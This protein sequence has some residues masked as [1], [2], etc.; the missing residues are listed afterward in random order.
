MSARSG[1]SF[2]PVLLCAV[3]AFGEN[4][5]AEPA[6]VG[7]AFRYSLAATDGQAAAGPSPYPYLNG[8]SP[9]GPTVANSPDPLVGY[10][11]AR[12]SAADG[13]Q[14]YHLRPVAVRTSSPASFEGLESLTTPA[15]NVLVKGTGSILFD[16]GVESAAWLEFDSADLSGSVTMSISEYNEPAIVNE[17]AQ[18]P[19][20]TKAPARHENVYR[21]ELNRELY[22]GV[23]FGWIHVNSFEK[24]W[25]ITG[26]RLVCQIKPTNYTGAFGCSDP[27]LERIWYTG[28]YGV[29]LNL[30]K[31]Y[32]GAILMERSDR[33]SWTGDAHTSQGVALVAFSNY[34]FVRHNIDRTAKDTN[35]IESYSLYWILSLLDYYGYTGDGKALEGYLPVVEAKLKRGAEVYARPVRLGFFGHDDRIGATFEYPDCVENQNA[36]RMLFLRTCREVSRAAGVAGRKELEAKY[37]AWADDRIAE[38]RK[39]AEWYA[40]YGI[41]ACAEAVNAGFTTETEQAAIFRKEFA[42]PVQRVSYSPFNQ[43]FLLQ[44]MARMGRYDEAI[45]SVRRC[46]GGQLELGATTFWEVF[47]PEWK[48]ILKPNDPV[49]NCQC[50]YT[51]LCH[52]WSGGVTKWLSEEVLGIRPTAPGFVAYE[53]MPHLGRTLTGVEGKVETPLGEI[54]MALDVRRGRYAVK[55]PPGTVGTIGVPKVERRIRLVRLGDATVWDGAFHAVTGITGAR[56]DAGFV[57]LTGVQPGAYRFQIEYEGDTPPY[58]PPPVTYAATFVKE[59]VTTRGNWGGTY[60]KDGYALFSYDGPGH[61]VF[62][63][64]AYV[65]ELRFPNGI[66]APRPVQWSANTTDVRAPAPDAGNGNPR[67]AGAMATQNPR[68]CFQTMSVTVDAK[69]PREYELALYFVDWDHEDRRLTVELFDGQTNSLAAPVRMISKFDDGRYLVYRCRGSVKVR[70]NHVRG[71]DAVLSGIFFDGGNRK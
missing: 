10:R 36:Y 28:A 69:E 29:K 3:V 1:L 62:R 24:P 37:A 45:D 15:P 47:R 17:G 20:K 52:P 4:A 6:A 51:S 59:D 16:F 58:E 33:F 2:L 67:K 40:S 19:I 61:N 54:S 25:H 50:G 22:E 56:E 31:D 48:A 63:L 49:P 18:S 32:F 35:N 68:A 55:A 26:V 41:H 46:W 8:G 23:R 42:D 66:G 38:L 14:V 65:R 43:Y 57:Y 9:D 13:L 39:T 53:V 5:G 30:L 11:W 44:A 60:G 64:P 21:L 34:D 70:V 71:G 27:M 7:D 12:V